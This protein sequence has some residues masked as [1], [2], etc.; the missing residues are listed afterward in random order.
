MTLDALFRPRSVAVM[1]ASA[2]EHSIGHSV[3][4]NLQTFGSRGPIYPVHPSA[5]EIRGLPAYPSLAAI[6]GPV[7]LVHIAIPAA[8]VPQAMAECGAKG[9]RAVII[10]SAGFKETGAE[11]ERLQQAFLA[12]ARRH[13]IRVLGPNCQGIINTDPQLRAY[14]NFTNT[15]PRPGT[16]SLAALSGGV[17]GF[18]LQGL[19]DIG[20]GLRMYA[21]NGNACDVSMAEIL[22]YWGD[23]PGT[24]VIVL[25]TEGFADPRGLPGGGCRGGATQARAG[26][27][28]RAHRARRQG[29]RVAHRCA[30]RGGH[31]HRAD[32]RADR[33]A[34]LH[35]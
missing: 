17:G 1:G 33:H 6:P 24:E 20:V 15:H 27:E 7:D 19:A 14:C 2:R 8:Q 34:G 11:G 3:V 13:G 35:R 29:G 23:D 9:V 26:D 30:G 12:E 5:A 16:V 28:G 31:R 18:I 10:N 22:R 25:Y 32:L 21:S 4:Q